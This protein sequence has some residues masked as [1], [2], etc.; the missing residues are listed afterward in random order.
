MLFSAQL[1][2]SVDSVSGPQRGERRRGGLHFVSYPDS[3][4]PR[5]MPL[6]SAG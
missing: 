2:G 3:F 5:F 1:D 4:I 6:A